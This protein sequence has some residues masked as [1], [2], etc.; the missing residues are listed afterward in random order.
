[1]RRHRH[2]NNFVV[3]LMLT[4][5]NELL[6]TYIIIFYCIVDDYIVFYLWLIAVRTDLLVMLML[7][8]MR[9]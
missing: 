3:M 1:M 6:R 4:L 5:S 8:L 2:R 9:R 7:M